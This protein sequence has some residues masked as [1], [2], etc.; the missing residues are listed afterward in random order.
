MA[1]MRRRVLDGVCVLFL[2]TIPL[3]YDAL[4]HGVLSPRDQQWCCYA[5]LAVVLL[6]MLIRNIWVSSFLLLSMIHFFL[7][8]NKYSEG[9]L[10]LTAICSLTYYVFSTIRVKHYKAALMSFVF[11]NALITATRLLKPEILIYFKEIPN[12]MLGVS[13]L[14]IPA[15]STISPLLWILGFIMVLLGVS[16]IPIV[17]FISALL[18]YLWHLHKK[19]LY[20]IVPLLLI[21]LPFTAHPRQSSLI[22]THAW[23]MVVSKTLLC[24]FYGMGM[25]SFKE[26]ILLEFHKEGQPSKWVQ[27]R[28][29]AE[30]AKAVNQV[31]DQYKDWTQFRWDNPHCEFLYIFFEYGLLG[32]FLVF[33]FIW[34]ILSRF[35]YYSTRTTMMD[36]IEVIGLMASF[37]ALLIIC[38]SHFPFFL[39]R[40][41]CIAI[42]LT[43]IL[44]RKLP[45]KD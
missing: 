41:N 39:A 2:F 35:Y 24:P 22:R 21:A 40:M 36:R 45:S 8:W 37:I 12:G 6:A 29:V 27:Y 31:L 44:D 14:I 13:A 15:I 19:L 25:G 17:A 33:G 4:R 3:F 30:N 34:N 28:D 42:A 5:V 7:L 26:Q 16:F 38:T 11:I 32:L 20:V 18:F 10:Y 1:S 9:Q 43:A 23:Q